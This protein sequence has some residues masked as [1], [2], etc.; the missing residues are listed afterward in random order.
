LEQL[1]QAQVSQAQL[2][3]VQ[4][5]VVQL[6]QGQLPRGLLLQALVPQVHQRLAWVTCCQAPQVRSLLRFLFFQPATLVL[7]PSQQRPQHLCHWMLSPVLP[8]LSC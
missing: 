1:L 5:L 3:L 2:S 6:L 7:Q 4:V 8:L